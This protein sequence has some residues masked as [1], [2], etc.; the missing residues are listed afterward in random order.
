M[1]FRKKGFLSWWIEVRQIKLRWRH[2]GWLRLARTL[3]AIGQDIVLTP[4]DVTSEHGYSDYRIVAMLYFTRALSALQAVIV[5]AGRGMVSE[6]NQIS[7]GMIETTAVLAGLHKS[8]QAFVKEL[9]SADYAEREA[10]GNWFLNNPSVTEHVGE[11]NKEKLR[12]FLDDL[13]KAEFPIKKL[14]IG[15]VAAQTGLNELYAIYRHLSHNYGHASITAVGKFTSTDPVTGAK[16]IFWAPE[17][18]DLY[19]DETIG[20]A[21]SIFF[22]ALL[23]MDEVL[24]TDGVAARISSAFEIYKSLADKFSKKP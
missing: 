21:C 14:V 16:S 2:H 10:S 20:Q 1:S 18:G 23:A 17:Y 7:R 22:G 8:K 3:N 4:K 13:E 5:L 9:A 24:P 15:N 11:E 12:K 19:M 6:A